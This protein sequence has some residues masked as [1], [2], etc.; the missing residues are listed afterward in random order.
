MQATK[1]TSKKIYHEPRNQVGAK[2]PLF[3]RL[4]DDNPVEKIDPSH[5]LVLTTRQLIESIQ[6]EIGAILGTRLTAKNADYDDLIQNPLNFGLPSL[7]GFQDFQ[8][9][10]ASSPSQWGRI[11]QL[12]QR[13][14]NAFEPRIS[15]VQVKV[16]QFNKL[17]Q[18]LEIQVTGTIRLEKFREVVHFPVM[19]DC[20]QSR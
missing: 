17:K 5:K 6:R 19:L 2:P 15:D 7:F 11:C 16:D 12:C 13:A 20:S 14:I 9:F 8:S 10:D 1:Q 4:I 3:D 18:S